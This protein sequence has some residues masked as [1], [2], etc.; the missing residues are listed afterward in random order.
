MKVAGILGVKGGTGAIVEYFGPGA[1][2]ISATGK[3]TVCNM[4][5]EIGAT[6]SLF[7]YDANT[8]RYLRATGREAIAGLADRC[9][10]PPRPRRRCRRRSRTLLRSCRRGRPVGVGTAPGRAAHAGSRPAGL[11]H[12]GRGRARGLPARDLGRARRLVHELVVRGHRTRRAR[13]APGRGAWTA[14]AVAA[15]GHAGIGASARHDRARRPARRSR[16]HRRDRPRQRLRPVHRS[17]AACRRA[18]GSE[19]DRHVVQPQLPGAQRRQREHARIHRVPRNRCG[20]GAR[21]TARRF[22]PARVRSAHRRRPARARLRAG[23]V[24]FVAPADEPD[25]VTI[26]VPAGSDRIEL[27]EPFAAWDGDDLRGLRVLLKAVGK[28][29]T[30]QVS[31]AGKWLQYR[32]HLTNISRNLFLGANNAFADAAPGLGI[33]ARDGSVL[34]LPDLARA[35]QDR[36]HRLDRGRRRELRRGLVASLPRWS[37]DTW[38]GGQYLLDRS[39]GSRSRT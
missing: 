8:A 26:T 11:G 33:D 18:G 32:G 30:D 10:E 7:P 12:R 1:Q 13:R 38:V 6:C 37:R 19:R 9:A 35:V 27:L 20:D 5:A 28:C 3:A 39:R 16:G 21:R 34:P 23:A 17:V 36:G 4:G 24:G 15:H 29:T 2:S 31:P 22:V 25:E 14:S